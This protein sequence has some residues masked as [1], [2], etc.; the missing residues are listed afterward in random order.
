M[1]GSSHTST[2]TSLKKTCQSCL[3]IGCFDHPIHRNPETVPSVPQGDP[4][5]VTVFGQSSGAYATCTL[6]VAPEAKGLFQQ[7]ILQSG[8][9]KNVLVF[10]AKLPLSLW[11]PGCV[12]LFSFWLSRSLYLQTFIVLTFWKV[13]VLVDLPTEVP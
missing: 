3:P 8:A 6:T 2:A 9:A 7:A 5:R 1:A 4:D 13:L 12:F 10:V 11:G